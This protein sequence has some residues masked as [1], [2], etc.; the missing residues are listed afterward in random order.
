M[1]AKILFFL[2]FYRNGPHKVLSVEKGKVVLLKV[3]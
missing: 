1:I 2:R 3:R